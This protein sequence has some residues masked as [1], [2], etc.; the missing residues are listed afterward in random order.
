[1][2]IEA[3]ETSLS[4]AKRI[5]FF[6]SESQNEPSVMGLVF[7]YEPIFEA[8][9]A[10]KTLQGKFKNRDITVSLRKRSPGIAVSIISNSTSEVFNLT[11]TRETG[12]NEFVAHLPATTPFVLVIFQDAERGLTM[13]QTN[14]P[15]SPIVVQGYSVG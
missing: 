12:M 13:M 1:M 4:K 11:P 9:E 7:D 14:D 5:D 8:I 3:I 2:K 10:Y 6:C 15:F